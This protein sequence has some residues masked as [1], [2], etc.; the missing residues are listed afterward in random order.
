MGAEGRE[1]PHV[2]RVVHALDGLLRAFGRRRRLDTPS[3]LPKGIDDDLQPI[4]RVGVIGARV[5]LEHRGIEV[6]RHVAH[7]A[8]LQQQW[9][10]I[11]A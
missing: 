6:D 4:R 5:V 7:I 2:L 3:F 10:T 9:A 11:D 1:T 8:S